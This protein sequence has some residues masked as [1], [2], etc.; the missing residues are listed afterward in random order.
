MDNPNKLPVFRTFGNAIGFA[1][2]NYFTVLRLA[3]LPFT[4]LIAAQAGLSYAV[5]IS[6]AKRVVNPWVVFEH[7]DQL[8]FLQVVTWIL[9]LL[10]VAAIA[11]SIHRIILFGDR[12]PGVYFSFRFRRTEFVYAVMA[13]LWALMIFAIIIAFIGPV[14]LLISGGDFADLIARIQEI[15]KDW[16]KNADKIATQIGPLIGLWAA[17]MAGWITV[18]YVSLR[19]CV[20]PPSIVATNRL[21]PSEPW[22]LTR[23]NAAGLFGLFVLTI[24]VCYFIIGVVAGATVFSLGDHLGD[25]T[26]PPPPTSSDPDAV[27]RHVEEVVE[28]LLPYWPLL[29]LGMLL[30]YTFVIGLVIALLSYSYKA[31]KGYDPTSPI[32][33]EG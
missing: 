33:D 7:I 3:W 23:G 21:S 13:A 24:F 31:L 10:V 16:P 14:L 26:P 20:W 1:F 12:R 15:T 28:K 6:L 32:A 19:L 25:F 18:L 5:G 9:Q 17:Y 30:F 29:W 27:R 11:V 4:L 2:G 22:R 8:L